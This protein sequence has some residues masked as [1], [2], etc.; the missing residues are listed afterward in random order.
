MSHHG[1]DASA[2]NLPSFTA[3]LDVQKS[4]WALGT[5][6]PDAKAKKH[7]LPIEVS[8]VTNVF[9]L[10]HWPLHHTPYRPR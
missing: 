4:A 1:F 7:M 6:I 8:F 5:P 10:P 3:N 9:T 2:Y